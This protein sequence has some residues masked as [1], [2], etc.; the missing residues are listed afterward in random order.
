MDNGYHLD[1]LT[2]ALEAVY[3][4][5]MRK[6][7]FELSPK[8]SKAEKAAQ[9]K[10][11]F[12][13]VVVRGVVKRS[14]A[15]IERCKGLTKKFMKHTTVAVLSIF[16]YLYAKISDLVGVRGGCLLLGNFVPQVHPSPVAFC[17]S[18]EFCVSPDIMCLSPNGILVLS[19]FNFC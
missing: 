13:S 10:P 11:G 12:V 9:G 5:I 8:P 2:E 3:P 6:I 15:W 1:K 7:R 17:V 4:G 19:K 14:N 18:P 16:S